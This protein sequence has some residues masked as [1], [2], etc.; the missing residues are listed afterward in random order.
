MPIRAVA[1]PADAIAY[2]SLA[3]GW[4]GGVIPIYLNGERFGYVTVDAN[5][6]AGAELAR[7][8]ERYDDRDAQVEIGL[9]E[10]RRQAGPTQCTVL[11]A[12]V[13]TRDSA[14]RAARFRPLPAVVLRMGKSCRRLC[15]WPLG[16]ILPWAAVESSNKRL[17]Y[18]LHAPQKYA[19]PEALRIP[20]PGTFLRLGRK[21]PAPIVTT[22]LELDSYDRGR[23]TGRLKE[24]PR[25]WVQRQRESGAWR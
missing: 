7:R 11:W 12:W 6:Q 24:P 16:E 10:R 4:V 3:I 18:A 5:P 2:L 14:K 22:R 13:E 8:A 9:P 20:L 1:T 23:V 17:A 19:K 15:L 21:V 25:P